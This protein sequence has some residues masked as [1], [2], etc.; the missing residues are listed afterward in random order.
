MIVSNDTGAA[1]DKATNWKSINWT[2]VE[3]VV[4][5][6]QARI[7]KATKEG[8]WN[9]VKALQRLL[10]TSHSGKA[11]AVLRVTGNP[12]SKTPGVDGEIWVTP[13]QK[14]AALQQLHSRGYKPQP[15]RR[16][17]IPKS[18]GKMRPLGIPTIRDRAMQALYLL[19]L[20]PVVE[21][22]SDLN[23]YG[24]RRYRSTAD[25]IGKCHLLLANKHGAQY[26]LEADI[27]ACFDQIGHEWLLK[28]APMNK[29]ML[30][31]WLKSGYMEKNAFHHTNAGTPQ[32]GVISPT[33]ANF[34]LNGLEPLLKR[35]FPSRSPRPKVNLVRYCD[36]FVITGNSKEL[37]EDQVM[38]V[39]AE[40]L[41]ER[42]LEFSPEKTFITHISD[43]FDFLGQNLRRYNGKKTL[44][45]P[46]KK[47]VQTFLRKVQ[48]LINK[49]LHTEQTLL[50][51]LLNQAIRGWANYHRHACS[52]VV[53]GYVDYRIFEMVWKWSLRR[54]PNK[55]KGWIAGKYFGTMGNRNWVFQTTI[56][57][58]GLEKTI[59]LFKASDVPI[60]RHRMIKG[61]T[62]PYDPLWWSYLE[63]R[64]ISKQKAAALPGRRVTKT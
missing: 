4:R 41:R 31:K 47:N 37:L 38:P 11:L 32:G 12:G 6:L 39:V 16:L 27:K 42:G 61:E 26:V 50:I 59:R 10:T 62:N 13:F 22:L 17:Y 60:K 19:A 28:H 57:V 53:F 23:S 58:R 36:D 40:F 34:A 54:H 43:G 51:K 48:E 14:H 46:S 52:K 9:K 30:R 45:K 49:H 3:A 8:K 15:L 35:L 56:T 2:Q 21:T 63:N 29:Q 55:S 1:S 64:Q 20:D 7:V 18:N 24:F 44:T 5:R 25:A 33:L